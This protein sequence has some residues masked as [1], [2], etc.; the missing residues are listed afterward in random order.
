MG[1]KNDA[2]TRAGWT[3]ESSSFGD[4]TRTTEI[5]V[6]R[7]AEVPG[8]TENSTVSIGLCISQPTVYQAARVFAYVQS[9]LGERVVFPWNHFAGPKELAALIN[10]LET[11]HNPHHVDALP[12]VYLDHNGNPIPLG[13]HEHGIQERLIK[14]RMTAKG[15]AKSP[16]IAQ[17]GQQIWKLSVSGGEKCSEQSFYRVVPEADGKPR[18]VTDAGCEVLSL[19]VYQG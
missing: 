5:T 14:R 18:V 17:S 16:P 10:R 1:Q 9:P 13:E 3:S 4:G 8:P 15:W 19:E 2:L 11:R 7:Y 12:L 6:L